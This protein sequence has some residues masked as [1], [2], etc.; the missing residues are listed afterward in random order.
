MAHH[1]LGRAVKEHLLDRASDRLRPSQQPTA[2]SAHVQRVQSVP[3][4]H[5][6]RRRHHDRGNSRE[7]HHSDAGVGERLQEVHREQHH[8]HHRQRD[9]HRREQHRPPGRG[10]RANQRLV[11]IHAVGEFVTEPADDQQRVVDRHRQTQC[12]SEVQRVDRHVGCVCDR[13]QHRHRTQ[14]REPTHGQWQHRGHE[15]AE[16]PDE[17]HEAQRDRDGFHKQQIFFAL[18]VDLDVGHR[19]AT[20]AH[21]EPVAVVHQPIGQL[22]GVLLRAALTAGDAG[23]DQPGLAVLADQCRRGRR[24]RGPR[25][26]DVGDIGRRLELARRGRRRRRGRLDFRRRRR[27]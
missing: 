7:R 26:V 13:A 6:R 18:A 17:H 10:H 25:R 5:D 20:R 27:R 19:V 9:R 16:H 11:P 8:R 2:Q 23:D 21:G 22:L 4:Q 15:A 24:R 14:D 3:E 1:E 12:D